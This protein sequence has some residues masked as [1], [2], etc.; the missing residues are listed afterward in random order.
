M[1]VTS[2]DQKS[3][4]LPVSGTRTVVRTRPEND[5][6]KMKENWTEL[7]YF[8]FNFC[9]NIVTTGLFDIRGIDEVK[10]TRSRPLIYTK[11]ILKDS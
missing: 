9:E 1:E 6:I 10:D 4:L 5:Q 2:Y 8:M 3:L 7:D 11:D